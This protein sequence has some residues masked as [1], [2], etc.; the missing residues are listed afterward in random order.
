MGQGFV[1]GIITSKLSINFLRRRFLNYYYQRWR[2]W[3]FESFKLSSG[4][5]LKTP[6][7]INK[8][9]SPVLEDQLKLWANFRDVKKNLKPP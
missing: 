8:K 1:Q 2:F 6:D 7:E 9:K 5:A 3:R 4:S